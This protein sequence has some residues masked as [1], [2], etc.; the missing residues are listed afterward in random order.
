MRMTANDDADDGAQ[1]LLLKNFHLCFG[2]V[3]LDFGYL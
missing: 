3:W 2:Q 1:T